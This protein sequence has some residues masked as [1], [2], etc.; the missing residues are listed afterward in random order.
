[1]ISKRTL[2][3]ELYRNIGMISF[4]IGITFLIIGIF[5]LTAIPHFYEAQS[6]S[7]S[8]DSTFTILINAFLWMGLCVLLIL[9]GHTYYFTQK[10]IEKIQVKEND[11]DVL[12][13]FLIA[14][15]IIIGTIGYIVLLL[16]NIIKPI[17]FFPH[18]LFVADI[19]LMDL[20]IVFNALTF[21]LILSLFHRVSEKFIKYGLK[22]GG[23][24]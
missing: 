13:F 10:D 9:I 24:K 23:E 11:F 3:S 4:L 19:M 17:Q 7:A 20:S 14:A 21:F 1:M 18:F 22:I 5:N 15:F 16:L 8:F 12:N 6:G 2:A